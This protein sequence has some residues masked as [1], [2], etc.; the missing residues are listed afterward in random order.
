MYIFPVEPQDSGAVCRVVCESSV[1]L[2]ALGSLFGAM[3]T[4]V[5][6]LKFSTKAIFGVPSVAQCFESV[7]MSNDIPR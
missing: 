1:R 2:S 7:P 3:T 5:L 4:L 6:D